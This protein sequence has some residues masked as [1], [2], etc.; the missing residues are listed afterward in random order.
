MLEDIEM[1]AISGLGTWYG[2]FAF[3][4]ISTPLN[5]ARHTMLPEECAQSYVQA[6]FRM[7]NLT[8]EAVSPAY[9]SSRRSDDNPYQN[10]GSDSPA[11][12]TVC[13]SSLCSE[14]ASSNGRRFLNEVRSSIQLLLVHF[15]KAAHIMPP[16][17]GE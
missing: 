1:K 7:K 9:P 16:E 6:G 15:T 10:K 14:L 12:E 11:S 2:W 8:P 13:K 4:P 5:G 3:Q 17:K